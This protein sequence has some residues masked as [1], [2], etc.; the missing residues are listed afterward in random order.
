MI[1]ASELLNRLPLH[2]RAG[3]P[4]F[5]TPDAVVLRMANYRSYDPSTAAKAMSNAGQRAG[6]NLATLRE[7]PD[8]VRDLVTSIRAVADPTGPHLEEAGAPE[9]DGDGVLEGRLVSRV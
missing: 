5:R 1:A 8:T 2:P 6:A 7:G 3:T 9:P 4:S